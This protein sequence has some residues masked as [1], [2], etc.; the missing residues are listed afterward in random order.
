MFERYTEK[1]RRT[2]FFSR[3]EA[4]QFGSP[5]IETEHLLLGIF[6]EDKFLTNKFLRSQAT[7]E[8]IRKQIEGQTTIRE[9]VS[10][11]VD[12]SLSEESKRILKYAAE[13]ADSLSDKHIGTEHLLLGVLRE[14]KCLA[15]KILH[16]HGVQLATA[17]EEVR[18]LV[19]DAPAGQL[20]K[21]PT[22]LSQYSVNLCDAADDSH[23][24]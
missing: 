12:I 1:A 15:A 11:S 13:E 22:L 16:D 6:R 7:L 23:H 19:R 21:E 20:I 9:A 24:S 17:R 5:Y 10:T 3:Y 18:R 4:S 2:I 14:E 8:S